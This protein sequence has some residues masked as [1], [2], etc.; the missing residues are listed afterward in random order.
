M[1][2]VS[3]IGARQAAFRVLSRVIGGGAYAD[4]LLEKELEGLGEADRHLTTEITYGVLRWRIRLDWVIDLFSSI[5]SKKLEHSVL[6]AL[7]IGAYQ[8]LFLTRVPASAAVNGSVELAK[9]GGGKKAGFVNAVLKKIDAGRAGIAYPDINADPIKYASIVYSHPEWMVK[10]WAERFGAEQAISLCESNQSVPP[11]T[12]RVNTLAASRERLID[13]LAGTGFAVKKTIYSPDG[14][15]VSSGG[16]LDPKDPRYYIQDEASQLIPYL[17]SPKP[18]EA[19]LDLCSAP[20]GK[21]THMAQLMGD[22]GLICA[23]DKRPRR[24]K[25]VAEAARRLKTGII[26]TVAAD[27]LDGIP[28]AMRFDAILLDAPCSGLGVLRRSPDIKYRRKEEDIRELAGVQRRLL[29]M[30]SGY[31]KK[32]GRMVYSTCTFE[33][34]ETDGVIKG[35]L[36][37]H[38]EF[39]LEDASGYMPEGCGGLVDASGFLRTYPLQGLDGFFGARLGLRP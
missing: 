28:F 20:G 22:S 19:I 38:N 2:K 26:R 15:E 36:K 17:L 34:E 25:N 7:R 18:G 30:A 4:I 1:P 9:R 14:I 16:R 27:A 6:N 21:A 8:L 31:L 39:V 12:L 3:T 13:E 24:L 32:G 35:F 23:V 33:P 11:K 37:D 29:E 5:K 10:R